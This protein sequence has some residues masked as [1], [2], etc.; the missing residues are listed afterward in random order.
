MAPYK[1]FETQRL[2]LRPTGVEDAAFIL[3]LLNTPKWLQ[4]IG[5]RKVK[6]L[7]DAQAYIETKM[8]PQLEK[9]G[10]S[11][12]TIIRKTDQAKIGTC[13]LYNREGLDGV[14]IGYA[15]LPQY[16]KQGY[17]LEAASIIKKAAFKDFNLTAIS[18]YTT[19]E[20]M[21][22]QLLL[23]KLGLKLMG[24][25]FIPNDDEELLLF[26]LEV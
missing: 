13:G 22:S 5:D 8:L 23:T 9:L 19:K 1:T 14:D 6:T 3:E 12:Y 24:T 15:L 4:N 7:D 26:K 25:T 20:N 17:A 11:N 21:A 2:F 18:A 16:E 10:Y